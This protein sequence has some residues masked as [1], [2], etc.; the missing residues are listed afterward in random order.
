MRADWPQELLT[1]QKQL[2]CAV[3]GLTT[4]AHLANTADGSSHGTTPRLSSFST[5]P[6]SSMPSFGSTTSAAVAAASGGRR[7]SNG[8]NGLSFTSLAGNGAK[9]SAKHSQSHAGLAAGVSWGPAGMLGGSSNR[10]A[11]AA[12]G[13]GRRPSS[14]NGS[15][16]GDR[17]ATE[18]GM[19]GQGSS[20]AGVGSSLWQQGPLQSISGSM[21][22]VFAV[23]C[24]FWLY[25]CHWCMM[26]GCLVSNANGIK[27]VSKHCV[28]TCR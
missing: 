10:A 2:D 25:I 13:Q 3:A 23:A 27:R 28:Q 14:A 19:E 18:Q 8:G 7:S 21:T 4:P 24:C 12:L 15:S 17:G 20:A 1:H 26:C 5:V 9:T 16:I 6:V 22:G 11:A